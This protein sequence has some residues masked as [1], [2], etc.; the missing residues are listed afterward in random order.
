[1]LH[2]CFLTKKTSIEGHLLI[3]LQHSTI[4]EHDHCPMVTIMTDTSSKHALHE[5][6][7]HSL[8]VAS[9][10]ENDSLMAYFGDVWRLCEALWGDLPNLASSLRKMKSSIF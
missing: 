2:I 4:E 5:H 7:T 6:K 10:L 1:M 9:N 8:K 3:Q